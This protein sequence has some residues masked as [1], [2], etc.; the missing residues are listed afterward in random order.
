M[1]LLWI[2][3]RLANS[4]EIKAVDVGIALIPFILWMATAGILKKVEIPGIGTIELT[5]VFVD[6]AAVQIQDQISKIPVLRFSL[7]T[8]TFYPCLAIVIGNDK[9]MAMQFTQR[10][11]Q[12]T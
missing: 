8:E 10:H 5:D 11:F 6:A 9:R 2:K 3:S 12:I 7:K 1:L 4:I